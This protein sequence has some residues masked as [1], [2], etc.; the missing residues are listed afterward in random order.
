M[1]AQAGLPMEKYLALP[2]VGASTLKLIVQECPLAAWY[3]SHLNP[4]RPAD[5]TDASDLGTLAHSILLEGDPGKVCVINPEDYPAKNGN[6]PEGWTNNA[7]RAARDEARANGLMPMLPWDMIAAQSI[8]D[9]AKA[10]IE[11]LRDTEP[12]IWAMFQPGGGD[13]ELTVQWTDA[14]TPCKMRPDRISNDQRLIVDLKTSAMSVNPA[15]WKMDYF[16]ASYYRRGGRAAFGVDNQYVFLCVNTKAPYLCSLIGVDEHHYEIGAAQVD[17]ALNLWRKCVAANRWPG[18]ANRVY[19]PEMRPWVE[20][21]WEETR[22]GYE[23]NLETM[24]GEKK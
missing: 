13:S 24:W 6:V 21:G 18:Y 7:I 10:F 12:A 9:A 20:S 17:F 14:G 1:S 4:N 15:E 16:G 5:D 19:W 23:Y 2:A 22:A 8:V 3:A 11:T